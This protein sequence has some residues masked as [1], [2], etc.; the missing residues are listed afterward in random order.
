[1]IVD[2]TIAV[3]HMTRSSYELMWIFNFVQLTPRL[4]IGDVH[5]DIQKLRVIDKVKA[6]V[7]NVIE[8]RVC[9][10]QSVTNWT[11]T[12][13]THTNVDTWNNNCSSHKIDVDCKT[14]NSK[15]KTVCLIGIQL[16]NR[17][18]WCLVMALATQ[19][20]VC[21]VF[22]LALN[23]TT[24]KNIADKNRASLFFPSFFRC[25]TRLTG[26]FGHFLRN[27]GSGSD[28]FARCRLDHCFDAWWIVSK[29]V[30]CALR[31]CFFCV[32]FFAFCFWSSLAQRLC[33]ARR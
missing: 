24:A 25:T 17:N 33:D 13:H 29:W 28:F 2:F 15:K 6:S 3:G 8:Q 14:T 16:W 4:F 5:H 1:M 30:W 9:V 22:V 18:P 21:L 12:T 27:L 23:A 32:F 10:D 20:Y 7:E 31:E 26:E 19:K 11:P